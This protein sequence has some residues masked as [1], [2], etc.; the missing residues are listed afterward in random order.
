MTDISSSLVQPNRFMSARLDLC[1]VT[2]LHQHAKGLHQLSTQKCADVLH[3]V[4]YCG[5]LEVSWKFMVSILMLGNTAEWFLLHGKTGLWS[6]FWAWMKFFSTSV[7]VH[8]KPTDQLL[9]LEL[10]VC[11]FCFFFKTLSCFAQRNT[12]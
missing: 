9:Y 8:T 1:C 10:C 5:S 6:C 2:L 12:S 7:M 11:G 3:D 4:F